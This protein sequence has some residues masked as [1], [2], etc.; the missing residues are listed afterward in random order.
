M[1]GIR[2]E[3]AV[4]FKWR[5]PGNHRLRWSEKSKN[6]VAGI[7][8]LVTAL[9][10]GT[11]V[12]QEIEV[13][14]GAPAF[15][16]SIVDGDTAPRAADG[17][18][19]GSADVPAGT[20]D[21][22]FRIRNLTSSGTLIVT[23]IT[24]N[25]GHFAIV[26]G[27]VVPGPIAPQGFHDF[28]VRFQPTAVGEQTALITIRNNDPDGNEDPYTFL[29][30]GTGTGDP[31]IAV[32][33][34]IG[35]AQGA[36]IQSGDTTPRT[37][38]GTDFG[39]L[40]L[41]VAGSSSKT[42]RVRNT[43]LAALTAT[44]SENAAAF[45]IGDGL[46]VMILPGGFDDFTVVFEPS[47]TGEKTATVT[48]ANDDPDEGTFTF[49]I[50]GL[51]LAP[52]IRVEGLG[53]R[54]VA[55]DTSPRLADGTDFETANVSGGAVE[56]TFQI[57]NNESDGGPLKIS[58]I[59]ENSGHFSIESGGVTPPGMVL[60]APNATHDFTVRFDPS[61][62][63][64]QTATVTIQHDDPDGNESPYT[65][66]LQGEGIGVSE[67]R[68]YGGMGFPHVIGNGLNAPAGIHGTDFGT[69]EVGQS[70]LSN[71]FQVRNPGTGT[72]FAEVTID[73]AD[74]TVTEPLLA[75][76]AP[77]GFNNFTIKFDPLSSGSKEATVSITSNAPG[78][79]PYT[80]VVGGNAVAPEIEVTGAGG[81]VILDGDSETSV[82]D[83]TDFGSVHFF[84]VP[85][86]KT[87][88]IKNTRTPGDGNPGNDLTITEISV[89][90]PSHFSI[91]AGAISGGNPV[92]IP[93]NGAH[94]FSVRFDPNAVG[95]LETTVTIRNNDPDGN[96]DPYTFKISGEGTGD[97][98]IMVFGKPIIGISDGEPI[99][100]GAVLT[101]AADGT[102]FGLVNVNQGSITRDFR[103]RNTGSGP[104]TVSV[105]EDSEDFLISSFLNGTIPP[106]GF[107]DFSIN[108]N[109]RSSDSPQR[110]GV[111]QATVTLT[112]N[113]PDVQ[114]FTYTIQGT[115]R[116]PEIRVFGG[117]GLDVHIADGAT[118]TNLANGTNFGFFEVANGAVEVPFRFRN[119]EESDGI[120]STRQLIIDDISV[121]G[122]D[123]SIGSGAPPP[124][125]T[126]SLDE[127]AEHDFTVRFSPGANGTKT[128]TVTIL[129]NDPDDE[130]DVF[131]FEVSASL[132]DPM[133]TV[134]GGDALDVVIA[135]GDETPD[136]EDG[137]HIGTSYSF[138]PDDPVLQ[139]FRL[140]NDSDSTLTFSS[141]LLDASSSG[142]GIS[143]AGV[144]LAPDATSDFTVSYQHQPGDGSRS[145]SA[146]I[147]IASNDPELPVYSFRVDV[148]RTVSSFYISSGSSF[149]G[150]FLPPDSET[151]QTTDGT[152]FGEAE[153]GGGMITHSFFIVNPT[154]FAVDVSI[155][156][157]SSD[158]VVTGFPS[159]VPPHW[160]DQFDIAFQPTSVGGRNAVISITNDSNP[161]SKIYDFSVAGTGIPAGTSPA[162]LS[163]LR[164]DGETIEMEFNAPLGTT[165]RL[166]T[167]ED[168]VTFVPV[169]GFTDLAGTGGSIPISLDGLF[170]IGSR[171]Y[172]R[173]EEVA[174][175]P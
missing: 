17:T 20:V 82:A 157:D 151:V 94:N 59:T 104:L 150:V 45:R 139:V 158:F 160:F 32:F 97:P 55:G 118:T 51:A 44:V 103:V 67:I 166:T 52:E 149:P 156:S 71:I 37:T 137:T 42:F 146:T 93:E 87:F 147:S 162:G 15:T 8:A 96:E 39:N 50:R 10:T 98:E 126:I 6:I 24:D 135:P 58:G 169:A 115:A 129:T 77:G 66:R 101:R 43:G 132:G 4:G 120:P 21:N 9:A 38:D 110:N 30:R 171:R 142:F 167:S 133:F 165:Y 173:L 62:S 53:L 95:L 131:T 28:T 92:L 48:I 75:A 122:A 123:F 109:P 34:L 31:E 138:F 25:S 11:A 164:I 148:D 114:I 74:F 102:T 168:L 26:S 18:D 124:G 73:S 47:N 1:S 134:L 14:G 152:Q 159:T 36:E 70:F 127:G 140:R 141:E 119:I 72:L 80:F 107:D 89:S 2:R 76:I 46:P 83:G 22:V 99:V 163:G 13:R 56:R 136:V 121:D 60:V 143:P 86:T 153:V 100:N 68:V 49:A 19:F 29:V 128:A 111:S 61:A 79:S 23:S 27:A 175:D 155:S 106:G 90:N 130:N 63:G 57:I 105:M 144:S 64:V 41:N 81:I 170:E 145:K 78:W 161:K 154:D 117:L 125:G 12:A 174:G 33:A 116:A 88:Q 3:C 84:G 91:T 113:D 112:S 7:V 172:F 54:I 85:V 65:F 35:A 69:Q 40:Q 108:F 16:L 5:F